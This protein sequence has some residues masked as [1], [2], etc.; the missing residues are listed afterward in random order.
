MKPGEF[1]AFPVPGVA[2]DVDDDYLTLF[3]RLRYFVDP[4]R[5][6]LH[7]QVSWRH[8]CLRSQQFLAEKQVVRW[9]PVKKVTL[10]RWMS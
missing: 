5:R 7:L 6:D 1:C 9:S 10:N 8:R 2:G 4:A 3:L